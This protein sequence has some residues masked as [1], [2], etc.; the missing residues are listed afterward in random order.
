MCRVAHE[1]G[2]SVLH[3]FYNLLTTGS[4]CNALMI[5]CPVMSARG[6]ESK[7]TTTVSESMSTY[8]LRKSVLICKVYP[9]VNVLP[10]V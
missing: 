1:C 2:A 6:L 10:G 8:E 5:N 3:C 7:L 4:V 9:V